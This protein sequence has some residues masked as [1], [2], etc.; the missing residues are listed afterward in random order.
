MLAIFKNGEDIA[1]TSY[2]P[3]AAT[4]ILPKIYEVVVRVKLIWK[5][6]EIIN[7]N[8]LIWPIMNKIQAKYKKPGNIWL[9]DYQTM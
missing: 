8:N 6:T 9:I 7:N 4:T 3:I 5:Q 1:P 2:R